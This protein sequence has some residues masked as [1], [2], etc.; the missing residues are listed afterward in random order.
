VS[1]SS[2]TAHDFTGCPWLGVDLIWSCQET[3]GRAPVC[4]QGTV[5]VVQVGDNRAMFRI[6]ELKR[7]TSRWRWSGLGDGCDRD[8]RESLVLSST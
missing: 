3:L 2:L 8:L 1:E 7:E 4:A 6:S 5:A